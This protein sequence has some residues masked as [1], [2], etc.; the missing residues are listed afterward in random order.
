MNRTF[1]NTPGF[2]YS[3]LVHH[4]NLLRTEWNISG[5]CKQKVVLKVCNGLWKIIG[6]KSPKNTN[7]PAVL[8]DHITVFVNTS[9]GSL[10]YISHKVAPPKITPTQRFSKVLLA[11]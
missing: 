6:Y 4:G 3:N 2:N 10:C 5:K 11:L 7:R 8:Y 1:L 9:K